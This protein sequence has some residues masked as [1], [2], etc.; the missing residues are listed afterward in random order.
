MTEFN[1]FTGQPLPTTSKR[2]LSLVEDLLERKLKPKDDAPLPKITVHNVD[3]PIERWPGDLTRNVEEEIRAKVFSVLG[4]LPSEWESLDET[5][6]VPW[7]Q[8]AVEKTADGTGEA[9]NGKPLSKTEHDVSTDPSLSENETKIL[10]YLFEQDPILKGQSDIAAG[11]DLARATVSACL[12]HLRLI[13]IVHRPD[14]ERKGEGLTPKGKPIASRLA[15]IP[16]R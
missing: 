13:G 6:R 11:T 8:A 3:E 5:K 2:Y 4:S 12:R 14:G 16:P 9:E 10:L 1:C 7:L 15:Q